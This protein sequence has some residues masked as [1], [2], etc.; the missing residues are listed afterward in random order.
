[1]NY[2][3]FL[4]YTFIPQWAADFSIAKVYYIELYSGCQ[5]LLRH[6]QDNYIQFD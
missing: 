3:Y 2:Y 1:M 4:L 5:E 6:R